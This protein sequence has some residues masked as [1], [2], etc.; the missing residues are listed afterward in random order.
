MNIPLVGRSKR[1]GSCGTLAP[2]GTLSAVAVFVFPLILYGLTLAPTVTFEDS[3]EFI[4]AAFTLGVPHPSGY[5]LWCLLA[6]AFTWLPFGEIAQRVHLCSAVFAAATVWLTYLVALNLTRHRGAAWIAAIALGV[7]RV[8]WSQAV[9]AEVYTLNSFFTVLLIYLVLRWK[10]SRTRGWLYLLALSLGLGLANHLLISL[11]A[12]VLFI[13][14]LTIDWRAL[15]K[16]RVLSIGTLLIL[17]GLSVYL[18]LPLRAISDPPIN[19]GNPDT[20]TK[21]WAHFKRDMYRGDHEQI[22]SLGNAVDV[23]LHAGEAWVGTARALSWPLTLLALYGALTWV[24]EHRE[25]LMITLGI[26]ILNTL[27]LNL[28]LWA[29]FNSWGIYTHRVYYIPV[30]IVAAFWLAAA[31]QKLL[32]RASR[33]VAAYRWG[34][35]IALAAALVTALLLNYPVTHRQGDLRARNYALDLLD[36]TP[37]NAGVLPLADEVVFPL[38]HLKWVEGIR[39]DV[40]ILSES[41]G[42]KQQEVS[43]FM[44]GEPQSEALIRFQPS[45]EGF[46]SIPHGLGYLFVPRDNA[47][48]VSYRSFVPLPGPPRDLQLDWPGEDRYA[49]LVRSRY[50]AY[51]AR[52]GA[53]YFADGRRLEARVEFERAETINPGDAF[54]GVMLFEIYRHFGLYPERWRSL[55]VGALEQ[56]GRKVDPAIDRY[57]PLRRDQIEGLLRE[58]E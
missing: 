16:P 33:S 20:L 1:S 41:F 12:P 38:I 56:Y 18:Y 39:T 4:A 44:S 14:L 34:I 52:L 24:R 28:M 11:V 22:R 15:I 55:L 2:W 37:P 54:V 48:P 50:A 32:V 10:E 5:P 47:P 45:L 57:Y 29:Q 27:A 6:H 3:G 36:S 53:K 40:E 13:W 21:T 25:M 35:R 43:V 46:V 51:H 8:L 7:S 30:Q 42:W 31:C 26:A 9:I 49:D 17:A 58:L 23:A 19:V